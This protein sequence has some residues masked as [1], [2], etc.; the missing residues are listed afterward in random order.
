MSSRRT[1]YWCGDPA[2]SDDHVPPANL[3]PKDRRTNLITVPS[4][5]RHNEDLTKEDELFR[6]YVQA[7]SDSS[8]AL[9]L[10][11]DK[12]LR[13]LT[14]PGAEKFTEKIF[15]GSKPV[16]IAGKKTRALKVDPKRQALYFEK[17]TRG[18]YF[19]LFGRMAPSDITTFSPQ[20]Q[21]PGLDYVELARLLLP[22]LGHPTAKE[23]EV[24]QPEIFRYRYFH[25]RTPQEETFIV[26]MIFY[27]KVVAMGFF[28]NRA[29]PPQP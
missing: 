27:D 26:R 11:E 2:T 21:T 15:K 17:I 12:T 10:F 19:H 4:C 24:G 18:L 25:Q 14:R 6:F 20:F 22:P 7:V 5:R 28:G 13:S 29:L 3:F 16:L 9:R 1:C 23:G 8:H